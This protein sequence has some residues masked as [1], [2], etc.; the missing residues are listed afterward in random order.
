MIERRAQHIDDATVSGQIKVFWWWITVRRF[1]S[2]SDAVRW[3]GYDEDE[4]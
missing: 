2:M 1:S 4:I 3:L